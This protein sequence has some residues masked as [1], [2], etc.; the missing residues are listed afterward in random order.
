MFAL[1]CSVKRNGFIGAKDLDYQ[2]LPG[3]NNASEYALA[4]ASDAERNLVFVNRPRPRPAFVGETPEDYTRTRRH[5]KRTSIQIV[6]LGYNS[7]RRPS[8]LIYP[9]QPVDLTDIKNVL[10]ANQFRPDED[11]PDLL[12]ADDAAGTQ[13]EIR[14]Y[15]TKG[16]ILVSLN[17]RA[18]NNDAPDDAVGFQHLD[19]A[20]QSYLAL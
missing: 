14:L 18:P 4:P 10:L 11:D 7:Q 5:T 8:L 12:H 13:F 15:H 19:A 17:K 2:P 9:A 20:R 16:F 3:E 6:E 1:S